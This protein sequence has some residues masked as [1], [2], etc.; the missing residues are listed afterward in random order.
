MNKHSTT[1]YTVGSYR[2]SDIQLF[3]CNQPCI[4][5]NT[6]VI[7]EIKCTQRFAWWYQRVIPV[8]QPHYNRVLCSDIYFIRYIDIKRQ[9]ATKM[10][11][12]MFA[13]Q[14]H[15]SFLHS[16]IELNSNML[17]L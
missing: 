10:S 17:S 13:I 4:T 5:V 3:F 15:I 7:I 16:G 14:I 1:S 12:D 6:T 9:V 2:I 11:E 8:I